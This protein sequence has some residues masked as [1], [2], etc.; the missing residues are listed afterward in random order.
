VRL[1]AQGEREPVGFLWWAEA[2]AAGEPGAYV[3]GIEI[4]EDA[5]RR[6]FAG[7]ALRELERVAR[8]RGMRFVSL[9]VFGHNHDARRLYERLGFQ[10]TNITMRKSL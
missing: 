2:E 7:A 4:R 6:G 10:P 3:Y 1:H 5:R 8:A 9:H